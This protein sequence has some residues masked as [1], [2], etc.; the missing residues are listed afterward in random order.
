MWFLFFWVTDVEP[1]ELYSRRHKARDLCGEVKRAAQ[2]QLT[3]IS[4]V[5]WQ[6]TLQRLDHVAEVC[7]NAQRPEV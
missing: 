6:I 3:L 5:S 1:G 7:I 4:R 2:T